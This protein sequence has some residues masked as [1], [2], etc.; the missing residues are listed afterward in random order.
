MNLEQIFKGWLRGPL[1]TEARTATQSKAG[2]WA[3]IATI[4]SGDTG[5]TVTTNAVQSGDLI[6]LTAQSNTRQNSGFG[7]GFEVCSV[8]DNTSFDVAFAD[9]VSHRDG[10]TEIM[11]EIVKTS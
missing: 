3:G 8:V 6:R 2:D 1:G 11:W 9:G 10:D 4:N 7:V 5:V